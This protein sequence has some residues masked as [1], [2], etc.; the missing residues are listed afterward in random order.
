MNK[1][2]LC[3]LC[4]IVCVSLFAQPKLENHGD[5]ARIM[6]NDNI[7]FDISPTPITAKATPAA[8]ALY[9]FLT[10]NFGK[11]TISGMM[12][13]SMDRT[14]GTN[15]KTHEDIVAIYN[16]SG[17]YPA[18]VGFDL[19]NSTGKQIDCNDEWYKTYT[20][21]MLSLAIDTWG[22]GG[23][24]D[25]TWH[26]RDP[27]RETNEF[28]TNK[29]T[30][31]FTKALNADGTWNTSSMLYENIIKDIDM[32]AD[33]FLQ[34]QCQNV[35]CI[36]RPLHE[37]PGGWFW[38][39]AKGSEAYKKLYRLIYNEMVNVK[40]IYNI[41]WDWNADYKL[42]NS[43]CP[44]S[45]YFDI[46]ST[47]IYNNDFDYSSN[48]LAFQKLK[49][50]TQGKKIIALSE[51]GPIPDI[52][53]EEQDEA[54]WS[55]WMPWYQSWGGNF[56]NKT[57]NEQWKKCMNDPRVITLKDMPGWSNYISLDAIKVCSINYKND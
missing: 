32:V 52:E 29:V 54:M 22:K 12:T 44:G 37:A 45:E 14:V 19:M 43:W 26:W 41:V 2:V 33:Y 36:F 9:G 4:S 55:W 3:L 42:D 20:N 15:I 13:G 24:P 18:L 38:W 53:S 35:A 10:E 7:P 16:A 6:V 31:D 25:F 49:T 23:I 51:N 48:Y 30:F 50:L 34:L 8:R 27:S 5:C 21:R 40:G 11:R 47:D 17:H 1:S 57:S 46:V 39:G 28:Y 56:V